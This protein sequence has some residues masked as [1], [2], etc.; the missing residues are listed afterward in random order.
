MIMKERNKKVL[1]II[2][3]ATAIS[4]A[5]GIGI[6]IGKSMAELQPEITG[7]QKRIKELEVENEHL[8]KE[9]YRLYKR[10]ESLIYHL[11]QVVESGRNKSYQL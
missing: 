1:K 6:L 8:K 10:I 3:V 9:N 5:I 4:A 11:G 7:L 2:G